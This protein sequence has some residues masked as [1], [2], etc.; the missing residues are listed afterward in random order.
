[1]P[2]FG[3]PQARIAIIGLAP[4]KQGANRT[5]RPFTGDYAG[6]L[7]FAT[8]A[9]HGLTEGQYE[10]RPDDGLTVAKPRVRQHRAR[11]DGPAGRP[12]VGPPLIPQTG[13]CCGIRPER[14][15]GSSAS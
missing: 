12:P 14:R 9:R 11:C 2:S 4:G 1:V 3:D 5:G 10:A 7:L 8:L 13:S 15:T 6:D